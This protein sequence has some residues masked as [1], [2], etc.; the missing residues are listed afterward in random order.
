MFKYNWP[1]ISLAILCAILINYT[2]ENLY[3]MI[4]GAIHAS[5]SYKGNIAIPPFLT[6]LDGPALFGMKL[7][8]NLLQVLINLLI[9]MLIIRQLYP[10]GDHL[11]FFIKAYLATSSI[12]FVIL[13]FDYLWPF[14]VNRFGNFHLLSLLRSP[15]FPNVLAIFTVVFNKL[16]KDSKKGNHSDSFP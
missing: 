4:N 13:A 14:M 9:T 11:N 10:R 16:V 3:L 6:E 12:A 8:I 5:G 2:A 7:V 1:L 15:L